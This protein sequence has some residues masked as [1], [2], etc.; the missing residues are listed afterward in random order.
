MESPQGCS[1]SLSYIPMNSWHAQVAQAAPDPEHPDLPEH[2]APGAQAPL[3]P[4]HPKQQAWRVYPPPGLG[5][6]ATA[7]PWI[8]PCVTES[9]PYCS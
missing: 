2:P 4:E 1:M 6:F 8:I 9:A 5:G 7:K 3:A